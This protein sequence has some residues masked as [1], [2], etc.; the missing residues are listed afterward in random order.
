M[1]L[2]EFACAKGHV[3]EDLVP[4]GTKAVMC[5]ECMSDAIQ[6]GKCITPELVSAARILS[7]T[8]TNFEFADSRR[9]RSFV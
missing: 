5:P 7:P 9:K 4:V 2:Y 3:S 1:P 6:H 8:R